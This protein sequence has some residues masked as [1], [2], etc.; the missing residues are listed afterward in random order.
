MV[1][2]HEYIMS[3]SMSKFARIYIKWGGKQSNIGSQIGRKPELRFAKETFVETPELLVCLGFK[4][5]GQ[6][7]WVKNQSS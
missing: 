1:S 2:F 5:M 6:A 4:S 7:R 3:S